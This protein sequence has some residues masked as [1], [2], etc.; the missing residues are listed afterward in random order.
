LKKIVLA[1]KET[2]GLFGLNDQTLRF[3]ESA[4]NVTVDARGGNLFING[5]DQDVE[6][7]ERILTDYASLLS[8]GHQPSDRDL[9]LVLKQISE[10]RAYSLRDHFRIGTVNPGG[11]KT[12]TARTAN[13]LRYIQAIERSDLVFSIGPAGTGKSYLAVAVALQMLMTKRINRIILTRPA[14]EAGEKLGFLP[15]DLQEKVDPYLRPLYDALFD[16]MDYE[17]VERFLERRV[18]EIAPLA[19]MRG[20]TLGDSFIILD[21]GQNTTSE[22]M[23][24]FLTRIGLDS[25]V[26]VTG[27]VTQIDLPQG[28]R[29]GL[30]E[31]QQI[32]N[33]I[34]AIE[35]VYFTEKDVVRHALVKSIIRAY[36]DHA[37]RAPLD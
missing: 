20:R 25:K 15:G 35:F 9:K 28:K 17:R 27:D 33:G 6:A 36:E 12:V 31:A 37:K 34:E 16:L 8:E 2:G 18:I 4:L 26:V 3:L 11:K 19:F 1:E 21:E 29:S 5:D 13:Q 22:Q 14:V 23:K 24:M 7:V 30:V 10:D 32:F